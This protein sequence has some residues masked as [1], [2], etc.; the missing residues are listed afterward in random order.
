MKAWLFL[1][2]YHRPTIFI[3]LN[4]S[5]S[6]F[7][8]HVNPTCLLPLQFLSGYRRGL[9]PNPDLLCNRF[10]KFGAF[11]D[12]VHK[13]LNADYIATGHYA[14][15]LYPMCPTTQPPAISSSTSAATSSN[16]LSTGSA[17]N[18][19]GGLFSP[20]SSPSSFSSPS[21]PPHP[22]HVVK[23]LIVPAAALEGAAF[24]TRAITPEAMATTS[25]LQGYTFDALESARSFENTPYAEAYKH[26]SQSIGKPVPEPGSSR[27][28]TS[29]LSSSSPSS[30][31]S[32]TATAAESPA[33]GSIPPVRLVSSEDRHK[34]QTYFLSQVLAG[35]FNRWLFPVGHLNKTQVRQIA[36]EHQLPVAS[37]RDSM[38]L[39]FVGKRDSFS[40]FIDGYIEPTARKPGPII[41]VDDFARSLHIFDACP[42]VRKERIEGPFNARMPAKDPVDVYHEIRDLN[43]RSGRVPP[44]QL[45][46]TEHTG[47][48]HYTE[49]Q[50][51]SVGGQ[52]QALFI[53]RKRSED[54]T[55]CWRDY[56]L[57]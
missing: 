47:L 21:S 30:T 29:S 35:R 27:P 54:N 11:Q 12:Y 3:F 43:I 15:L 2:Q 22:T 23:H 16:S 19:K 46:V 17:A 52:D 48:V 13:H 44:R 37:K 25:S 55:V 45:A 50:R 36:A 38:G 53:L 31:A 4:L 8:L 5:S 14:R 49:G 39:C 34:D 56:L 32:S 57:E 1:H 28:F 42:P 6:F 51:A 24:Y 40:A 41:H 33:L 26:M 20:S 10:V 9:T 18:R 7:I